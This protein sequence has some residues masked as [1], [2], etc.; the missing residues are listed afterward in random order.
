MAS[1][2]YPKDLYFLSDGK[3]GGGKLHKTRNRPVLTD[4]PPL[5]PE[6]NS[7]ILVDHELLG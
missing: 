6:R 7:Y 5:F 1:G 3:K 2:K 4:S